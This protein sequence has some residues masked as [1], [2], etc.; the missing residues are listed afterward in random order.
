MSAVCLSIP[1][2]IRKQVRADALGDLE[3]AVNELSNWTSKL[4]S[5][6]LFYLNDRVT[7]H[8]IDSVSNG[9][10]PIDIITADILF[11]IHSFFS[12]QCLLKSWRADQLSKSLAYALEN[13]NLTMAAAAARALVE[14]ASA[15]TIESREVISVWAS[16][17]KKKIKTYRRVDRCRARAHQGF[18]RLSWRLT[19][20]TNLSMGVANARIQGSCGT[21]P[22]EHAVPHP[23]SDGYCCHI[24]KF[25]PKWIGT[26]RQ[27]RCIV[28]NDARDPADVRNVG[29]CCV[30]VAYAA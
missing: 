1:E 29:R 4:P 6:S 5:D 16:L 27:N 12:S 20:L 18:C 14:T 10:S 13:W 9:A 21:R 25:H 26:I 8:S 2:R 23:P 22:L 7:I 30:Q 15:W 24:R 3:N 11:D 19:R 17:K 28:E